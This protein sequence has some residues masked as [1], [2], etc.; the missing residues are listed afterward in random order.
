MQGVAGM[1]LGIAVD[2]SATPSWWTN[3]LNDVKI[4]SEF[5]S[6]RG[7]KGYLIIGK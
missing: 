3:M 6:I 5:L 7:D 4:F 2:H 1:V